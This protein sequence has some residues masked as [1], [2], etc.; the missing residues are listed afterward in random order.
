MEHYG[1]CGFDADVAPDG[2][3]RAV[4]LGGVEWI[5]LVIVRED[6]PQV[7]ERL[8]ALSRERM[9]TGQFCALEL[10][11]DADCERDVRDVLRRTGIRDWRYVEVYS[12]AA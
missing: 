1:R 7:A 5:G 11:P 12:L 3:V 6:V 4:G 8:V 9:P 10:L 2:T